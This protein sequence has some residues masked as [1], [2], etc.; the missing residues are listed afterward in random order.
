MSF[1]VYFNKIGCTSL[2]T[3]VTLYQSLIF[4]LKTLP[5]VFLKASYMTRIT[6][7]ACCNNRFRFVKAGKVHCRNNTYNSV[8]GLLNAEI[9]RFNL[10]G[11]FSGS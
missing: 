6:G 5:T 11:R 8:I 9:K 10:P 2:I 1:I 7:S 3:Y 4:A